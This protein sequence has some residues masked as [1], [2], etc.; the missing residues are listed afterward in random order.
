M[1]VAKLF[2]Q[3]GKENIMSKIGRKPIELKDTHVDVKGQD[4]HYKGKKG[5]G[6]FVLPQELAVKIEGSKLSILPKDAKDDSRETKMLWGMS[7]ALLAN[8]I[9]GSDVPFE[10]QIQINGL[11]FKALQAGKKLEFSLGFTHKINLDLP[12][13][14]TVEIDKTGQQLTFRSPDKELL[15]AICDKIRSFRPPEP[16]KGTGVKLAQETI[17]R[18]AGKAKASA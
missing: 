11:G 15:G 1:L 17:L 8:K 18:K 12:A 14:V 5:S 6:V 4:I 13:D 3:F 9:S 10:K 2:V 7:R 16:Y